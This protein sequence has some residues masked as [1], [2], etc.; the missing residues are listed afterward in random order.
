MV[1]QDSE[2]Y[3]R[4]LQLTAEGDILVDDQN[5]ANFIGG[6]NAV[7]TELK[8]LLLT[9]Q[10][11]DG[12]APDHGLR[13]F[14]VVGS[15]DSVLEREVKFALENDERVTKVTNVT[16]ED[17]PRPRTREVTVSV[18]LVNGKTVEFGVNLE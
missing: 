2:Q 13:L 6:H 5:Q 10:G 14:D 11:E 18:E 12:F 7:V 3:D 16:V 15:P 4:T 1:H 17:G 9:I 8:V